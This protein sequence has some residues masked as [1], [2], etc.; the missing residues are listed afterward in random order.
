[1]LQL[2]TGGNGGNSSQLQSG[3][4]HH[5]VA[6]PLQTSEMEM[7]ETRMRQRSERLAEKCTEF[8]LDVLGNN[9]KFEY[10]S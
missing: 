3:D 7:I 8:G 4:D 10:I 1:M 9:K 5:R 2:V 6:R